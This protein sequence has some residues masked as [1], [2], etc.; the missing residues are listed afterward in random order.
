MQSQK[1]GQQHKQGYQADLNKYFGKRLKIKLNAK[2]TIIGT[3]IGFDIFMNLVLDHCKE[4]IPGQGAENKDNLYPGFS[5]VTDQ[6]VDIGQAI[7]RGNSIIMW[8]CL[9]KVKD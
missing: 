5:N 7:V 9:D 6:L 4:L 2:R 8:E 3:V 1:R